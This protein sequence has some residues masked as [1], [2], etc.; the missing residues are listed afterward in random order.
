[1][2]I[3]RANVSRGGNGKGVVGESEDLFSWPVLHQLNNILSRESTTLCPGGA[4]I[5][6]L[7]PRVVGGRLT[8]AWLQ[9]P[10]IRP[11]QTH[12]AL[13]AQSMRTAPE[14]CFPAPPGTWKSFILV[15]KTDHVFQHLVRLQHRNAPGSW[16][17]RVSSR[18]V[19]NHHGAAEGKA[20]AHKKSGK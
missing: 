20:F 19:V 14:I 15:L 13:I 2:K 7:P 11:V 9:H 5:S 16:Q 6:F 17:H 1:M 10:P 18:H 8:P 4:R 12:P 3:T